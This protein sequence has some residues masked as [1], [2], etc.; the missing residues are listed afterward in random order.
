MWASME[1]RERGGGQ[2]LLTGDHSV[3][4]TEGTLSWHSTSLIAT[5]DPCSSGMRYFVGLTSGNEMLDNSTGVKITLAFTGLWNHIVPLQ[6]Q[7]RQIVHGK[8]VSL[9]CMNE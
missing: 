1:E 2:S 3:R 7:M 4:K 6:I 8:L 5:M 9:Q